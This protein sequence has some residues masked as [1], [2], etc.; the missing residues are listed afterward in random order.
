[1]ATDDW[2]AA[3]VQVGTRLA[4]ERY[5]LFVPPLTSRPDSFQPLKPPS[6]WAMLV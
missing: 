1:M 2:L 3:M 4:G 5:F 6:M